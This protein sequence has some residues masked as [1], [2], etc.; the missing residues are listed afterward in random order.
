MKA[1]LFMR[2]TEPQKLRGL[3]NLAKK[4]HQNIRF[5]METY[6]NHLPFLDVT[7]S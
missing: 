3:P 5:T 7:G 4:F 6:D 1:S 2:N